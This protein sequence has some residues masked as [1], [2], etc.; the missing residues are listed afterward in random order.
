MAKF[1]KVIPALK[2]GYAARLP[3]W[4]A[5][6]RLFVDNGVMV[7]QCGGSQPHSYDL[8]WYEIVADNWQVIESAPAT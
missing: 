8:S 7:Q 4:D 6:T 3:R 5:T 1:D 2:A